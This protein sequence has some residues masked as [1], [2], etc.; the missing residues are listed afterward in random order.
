MSQDVKKLT[1]DQLVSALSQAGVELPANKQKK[2][3]YV[4]LY[5][6]EVVPTLGDRPPVV[7]QT[8]VKSRK[9]TVGARK[10]RRT[11]KVNEEQEASQPS[12]SGQDEEDEPMSQS[13][14]N[15]DEELDRE[16]KR[17]RVT[18]D[19]DDDDMLRS[20]LLSSE[21]EVVTTSVP[22]HSI[23]QYPPVS[24]K[25][26]SI[27]ANIGHDGLARTS[28]VVVTQQPIAP[29]PIVPQPSRR[30]TMAA[31]IGNY[32]NTGPSYQS[33]VPP[34]RVRQSMGSYLNPSLMQRTVEQPVYEQ[35]QQPDDDLNDTREEVPTAPS[36]TKTTVST[37][38]L[39]PSQMER[40]AEAPSPNALRFVLV[41]VLGIVLAALYATFTKVTKDLHPSPYYCDSEGD[42]PIF[43][44]QDN[45]VDCPPHGYCNGGKL[46]ACDGP[47]YVIMN[48]RCILNE[49]VQKTAMKMIEET[50]TKLS[51]LGGDYECK[52]MF[53][54]TNNL[55]LQGLTRAQ[56]AD[57]LRARFPEAKTDVEFNLFWRN[58]EE[59]PEDYR[60]RIEKD[61]GEI[62]DGSKDFFQSTNPNL[63]LRCVIWKKL[64]EHREIIGGAI[65]VLILILIGNYIKKRRDQARIDMEDIIRIVLTQLRIRKR[66]I[67]VMLKAELKEGYPDM[68]VE[69]MW[70]RVRDVVSGNDPRVDEYVDPDTHNL[71]W[72]WRADENVGTSPNAFEPIHAPQNE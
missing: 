34:A 8:P 61:A 62:P 36:P 23:S 3:F 12:Q 15:E 1:V 4:D 28:A 19:E 2:Q 64:T 14:P 70:S 68:D 67:A 71:V 24:N 66:I 45:C 9:S 30:Q 37:Y 72:M 55:P 59:N 50:Q 53:G 63:P 58:L 13:Q 5:E 42:A 17:V 10:R 46:V 40:R 25:T 65:L 48:H 26:T 69:G 39:T 41:F 60:I 31:N 27:P 32:G 35:P 6:R 56:L 38:S 11:D 49:E 43:F 21:H 47:E 44:K 52:V 51:L 29:Q 33:T 57:H 7:V 22:R 20:Q 16:P 54:E 18:Q